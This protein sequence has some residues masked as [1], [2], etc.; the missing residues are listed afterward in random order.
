MCVSAEERKTK[1][2]RTGYVTDVQKSRAF[3]VSGNVILRRVIC[4][5]LLSP[6]RILEK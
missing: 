6:S 5:N 3:A 1:S 4:T 2:G